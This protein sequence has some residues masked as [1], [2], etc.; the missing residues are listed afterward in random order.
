MML[1]SIHGVCI[2]CGCTG[3]MYNTHNYIFQDIV[4]QIPHEEIIIPPT[5]LAQ[6]KTIKKSENLNLT[7]T[8]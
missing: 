8:P 1:T 3:K 5:Q 2:P 7:F 6:S 4:S